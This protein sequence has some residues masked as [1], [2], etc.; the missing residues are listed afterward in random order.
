MSLSKFQRNLQSARRPV[1]GRFRGQNREDLG[2]PKMCKKEILRGYPTKSFFG[3]FLPS[4]FNRKMALPVLQLQTAKCHEVALR[5]PKSSIF[6]ILRGYPTNRKKWHFSYR[7]MNRILVLCVLQLQTAKWFWGPKT[8]PRSSRELERQR[9]RTRRPH[10]GLLDRGPR[11][12]QNVQKSDFT[13]VPHKMHF[14]AIFLY[15]NE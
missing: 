7:K 13:G 3:H 14:L 15:K 2:G 12:S 11:R 5:G 6:G 8:R 10:F 4:I 9:A 1:F